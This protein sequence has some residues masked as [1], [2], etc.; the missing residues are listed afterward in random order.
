MDTEHSRDV[1]EVDDLPVVGGGDIEKL[2]EGSDVADQPFGRDLFPQVGLGVGAEELAPVLIAVLPEHRQAPGP[3]GPL[4]IECLA[5]L[6]EGEREEAVGVG[7]AGKEVGTA[8]AQLAGARP[9][10]NE[11]E[12]GGLDERVDLIQEGGN[13]LD[14]ID[15]TGEPPVALAVRQD[16][17]AQPS[18]VLRVVEKAPLRQEIDIQVI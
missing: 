14:L 7:A 5:Q 16:L 3:Q 9:G 11:G 8:P 6:G 10:E 15:R 13:L 17:L 1:A 2:A 12:P 18:R 4:E